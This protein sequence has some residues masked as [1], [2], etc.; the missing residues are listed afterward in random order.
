MT[1]SKKL[2]EQN[3]PLVMDNFCTK[4]H[5]VTFSGSKVIEGG[6]GAESAP[7]VLRSP[8]KPCTNRV[9][10]QVNFNVYVLLL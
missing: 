10:D 9:K 8:K 4:F 3:I 5:D 7:P 2:L 1:S 6:V